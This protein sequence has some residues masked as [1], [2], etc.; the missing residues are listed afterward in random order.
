MSE[1]IRML[2]VWS[3]WATVW[4]SNEVHVCSIFHNTI[5][6]QAVLKFQSP[7][8]NWATD[9]I[10]QFFPHKHTYK[11]IFLRHLGTLLL[12]THTAISIHEHNHNTTQ[13]PQVYASART[14][15]MSSLSFL[16]SLPLFLTMSLTIIF[17]DKSNLASCIYNVL[18]F[19]MNQQQCLYPVYHRPLPPLISAVSPL[20]HTLPLMCSDACQVRC[21]SGKPTPVTLHSLHIFT[22]LHGMTVT[23]PFI[24]IYHKLFISRSLHIVSRHTHTCIILHNHITR[25]HISS[26]TYWH[27]HENY[28]SV[29]SGHKSYYTVHAH[30]NKLNKVIV[31]KSKRL[32]FFITPQVS[33]N[34]SLPKHC[35]T[36]PH[37]AQTY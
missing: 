15:L 28:P 17:L 5:H 22:F 23:Y 10:L 29:S 32:N 9:P 37:M 7:Y 1:L 14:Y 24:N 12:F 36:G 4:H 31:L 35:Y 8:F 3:W 20:S 34:L 27:V 13:T 19:P 25:Y 21:S 18:L 26:I 11:I 16:F 6:V 30:P 2:N 33:R